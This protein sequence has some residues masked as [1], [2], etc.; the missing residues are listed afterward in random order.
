MKKYGVIVFLML[1][2]AS[3][4][5]SAN[6]IAN[7]PVLATNLT[8]LTFIEFK[9]TGSE[10]I[11]LQNTTPNVLSLKNYY[12]EYFNKN[13]PTLPGIPNNQQQLPD[14]ILATGQTILLSG[15]SAPTCGA[16]IAANLGFTLSD[17]S[18]YLRI[19]K[20]TPQ[21]DGVSLLYTPQD[22]VSWTS[23]TSGADLPKIPSNTTDPLAVWYRQLSNGS[24]KQNDLSGS[25]CALP[26][27]VTTSTGDSYSQLAQASAV[28]PSANETANPIPSDDAGLAA[29]KLS[30]VLPNPAPPQTDADDEFIELY[31]SN[32]QTFDLSGFIL[33]VG[34]STTHKYTIPAGTFLQP[35]QFGVFYSSE[36]DLSLSNTSGQ[37]KLLDPAGNVLEESDVYGTAKDGY[38]WVNADDAWQWTTQSTP[39]A[40]NIIISPPV[41][42][43]SSNKSATKG[44]VL[45]AKTSG[46]SGGGSSGGSSAPA[47]SSPVHPLILAGIGSAAVLYALYEYR[48]DLANALY[49]FRR[50]RAAG[51][52]VGQTTEVA[53]GF[54]TLL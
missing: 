3:Y 43:S 49:R 50:H 24:W 42:K 14:F 53:H 22:H 39:G 25:T 48:H 11:V 26:S 20:V 21:P 44:S 52:N 36:T 54:R 7:A 23:S 30:E 2:G 33:Q 13:N 34:L 51:R 12:L 28:V 4:F 5:L 47:K 10:S 6:I 1:F 35:Q 46:N 41:S 8:D 38:A 31:N 27:A 29:P 45:A 17:S 15:D 16:T 40:K 9:M 18:G 32:N 37:V 19:T